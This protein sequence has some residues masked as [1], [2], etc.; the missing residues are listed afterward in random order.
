LEELNGFFCDI[1][2]AICDLLTDLNLIYLKKIYDNSKFYWKNIKPVHII[3]TFRRC[4]SRFVGVDAIAP[5]FL[6]KALSCILSVV[7]HIF[8]FCLSADVYPGCG[9][10]LLFIQF[11]RSKILLLCLITGQSPYYVLSP[12]S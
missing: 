5:E 3:N 1:G 9:A 2:A 12:R 10:L 7:A 11:L 8:N 4:K 6:K